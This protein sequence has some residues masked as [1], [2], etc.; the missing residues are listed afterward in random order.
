M[1]IHVLLF[2]CAA[3]DRPSFESALQIEQIKSTLEASD[4]QLQGFDVGHL[5]K[6]SFRAISGGKDCPKLTFA[7]YGKV[8]TANT[9]HENNM[10]TNKK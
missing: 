10:S 4:W 5:P 3:I 8:K 6:C 2:V 7:A 9:V 1:Y